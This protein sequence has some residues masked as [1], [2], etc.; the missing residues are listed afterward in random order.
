MNDKKNEKAKKGAHAAGAA[1]APHRKRAAKAAAATG[2]ACALALGGT[3]A[4]FT[5]TDTITNSFGVV[6][7]SESGKEAL[8]INVTTPSWDASDAEHLVLPGV[9]Y[10]LDPQVANTEGVDAW[11][12]LKV[13]APAKAGATSIDDALFDLG[14]MGAGWKELKA[15]AIVGGSWVAYYGYEAKVTEGSST[16]ALFSQATY[17]ADLTADDVAALPGTVTIA[18]DGMA[19][20][21]QGFA[22][23]DAAFAATSWAA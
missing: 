2:L 18:C 7:A 1:S 4:Y 19:I 21:A 15:P 11:C 23:V 13:S 10:A 12:M 6:G 8:A 5:A 22:D 17:K 3:L 16:P 14:A 9:T 20:Q